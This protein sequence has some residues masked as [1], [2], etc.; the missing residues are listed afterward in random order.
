MLPLGK[1][2]EC[3]RNLLFEVEVLSALH[4]EVIFCVSFYSFVFA[5]H[6]SL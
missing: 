1:G 6:S 2:L 5:C 4:Y 3:N